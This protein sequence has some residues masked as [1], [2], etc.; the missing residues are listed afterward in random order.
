MLRVDIS[1]QAQK[2]SGICV[3]IS[4]ALTSIGL[5]FWGDPRELQLHGTKDLYS[6]VYFRGLWN[7]Y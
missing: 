4:V 7:R 3:R 2:L 1:S 5:I 6:M